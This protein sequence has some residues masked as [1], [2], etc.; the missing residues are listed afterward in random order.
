[1]NYL[2][3]KE[4]GTENEFNAHRYYFSRMSIK[5]IGLYLSQ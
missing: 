3:K 5:L 1:M 2:I 4:Y